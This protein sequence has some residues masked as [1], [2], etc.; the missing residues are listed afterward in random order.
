M[1]RYLKLFNWRYFWPPPTSWIGFPLF[2]SPPVSSSSLQI[3]CFCSIASFK[4]SNTFS[5]FSSIFFSS[6]EICCLSISVS[7][8]YCYVH[9]HAVSSITSDSST[10]I[11]LTNEVPIDFLFFAVT[12]LATFGVEIPC[13][14]YK[15]C[16]YSR[17]FFFSNLVAKG[18]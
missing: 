2:A 10:V 12:S 5:A 13:L 6:S 17:A 9:V 14:H 8:R 3:L 16:S 4:R 18:P 15:P 1:Q 7:W 11:F